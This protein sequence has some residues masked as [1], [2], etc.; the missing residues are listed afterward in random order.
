MV[1][2]ALADFANTEGHAWP[3]ME[4]L[5]AKCSRSEQT[6]REAVQRLARAGHITRT[7]R[8]GRPSL[9]VVHP[10][11]P[12]DIHE[13]SELH[14]G[15]SFPEGSRNQQ[16]SENHNPTPPNIP[17]GTPGKIQGGPLPISGPEPINNRSLNR[18]GEPSRGARARAG[19]LPEDWQ[20][21]P[22]TFGSVAEG[23]VATWENG[24]VHR[25]LS[26]FR[27]YWAAASGQRASKHDWQA[28]WRTWIATADEIG[29][30]SGGQR[31]RGSGWAA[32]PGME[33][34]EPVSLDD[35]YP[36]LA[37]SRARPANRKIGI[38]RDIDGAADE[39][40]FRL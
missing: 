1:L 39:L 14:E 19:R 40:G 26:K 29:K 27:D 36:G 13:G 32:R 35:E 21:A 16:G 34:V 5:A 37:P 24:R 6:V 33:G 2:L 30:R 22:L 7:A 18:S 3:S 15:Y 31:A 28:A 23:I 25:E 4:T 20:P 12:T 8:E 9:Y 11:T 38:S 10:V 17:E